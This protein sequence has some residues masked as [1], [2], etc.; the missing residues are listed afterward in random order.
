MLRL[1]SEKKLKIG[2]SDILTRFLLRILVFWGV[3]LSARVIDSRGFQ[4]TYC[5]LLNGS[6]SACRWTAERTFETE[7]TF[8]QHSQD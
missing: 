4:G 3:T 7:G 2:G 6:E 5:L 1:S 8:D